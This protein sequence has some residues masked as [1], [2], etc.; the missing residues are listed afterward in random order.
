MKKVFVSLI[1]VMFATNIFAVDF[2]MGLRGTVGVS[3][4]FMEILGE[5]EET[6]PL[7]SG[8]FG[9]VIGVQFVDWFSLEP[10]FMIHVGNGF[11]HAQVNKTTGYGELYTVMWTTFEFPL[12]AKFKL[13][14][15]KGKF[16]FAIGPQFNL[17][18]GDINRSV[19]SKGF[20][21]DYVY[22]TDDLDIYPYSLGAAAGIEYDFP[23][24][25]GNLVLGVRYQMDITNL[26]K[27]TNIPSGI[28]DSQW[29]NMAIL[30]SIA[31][32]FR[33]KSNSNGIVSGSILR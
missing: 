19:E 31:Y 11:S 20:T 4:A 25:P 27:N 13:A 24:G 9:A 7:L 3:S 17:L 2:L 30:P 5:K 22:T 6:E 23:V 16:V 14:V 28:K 10:E 21:E 32:T 15:G 18:L 33:I 26:C 1:A 12:M 8:S 29:R